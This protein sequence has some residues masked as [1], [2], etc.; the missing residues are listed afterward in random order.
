MSK[1]LIVIGG[2]TA[3]GKTELAIWLARNLETEIISADSRQIYREMDIGVARPSEEELSAVK[4]HFIATKSI[5]EYYNASMFENEALETINN[6]FY[7]YDNV[8]VAGGSG[9]YIDAIIKG[10]DDIPTVLPQIR[11]QLA[12]WYK[13]TSLTHIQQ[14]VQRL[15]PEYYAKA[16]VNNPMR[17]LK[18]LEVTIQ[19]NRP[20][21]SFLR[22]KSKKRP[23]NVIMIG[24]D[25]PRKELYERINSRT[26]KM[27]EKGLID[28]VKSLMPFRES[29]ALKT[30]GYKE[31]FD[32]LDGILTLEQAIDLIQRNT[33]KYARRQL[34]WF[35]RYKNIAW[36][37]PDEKE[38]IWEYL[39]KKISKFG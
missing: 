2:P 9:L 11:E 19:S 10:I 4:H 37:N 27:I 29:T 26:V 31:I 15:D 33:R 28:E 20:Y 16:D 18:A 23:F 24:L 32:Y 36:F 8:I 21:S 22:G 3:V 12:R 14:L 39:T 34:S 5:R 38:Q 35:R 13:E 6:L 7:K 1:N 30:V 17:L 25:R